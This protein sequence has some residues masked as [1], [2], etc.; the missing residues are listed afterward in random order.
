[1]KI[2]SVRF[3][4]RIQSDPE[5][6]F[7]EIY[8]VPTVAIG[9]CDEIDDTFGITND[10]YRKKAT[11]YYIGIV[12]LTRSYAIEFWCDRKEVA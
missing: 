12:W 11:V 10:G 1:M 6:N 5:L 3:R 2:Y 9:R 8:F 4:K 7:K